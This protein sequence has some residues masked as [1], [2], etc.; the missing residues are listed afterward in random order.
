MFTGLIEE[1][2]EVQQMK[3]YGDGFALTV[4]APR[5]TGSLAVGDSVNIDGVCQTV[6]SIDGELFSVVTIEET[7]KKT[8]LGEKRPG[9]HVNLERAL[10]ADSRLGGHFVLGHADTTGTI[11]SIEKLTA[12]AV[13]T[14]GYP[15]EFGKY[16]IPVGSI[17]VDGISLTLAEVEARRFKVAIIPH[18]LQETVLPHKAAGAKVNLEFDVL[19]K[20]VARMFD[21]DKPDVMTEEWLKKHGF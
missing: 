7:L 10:R 2:G 13:Y 12:S 9:T 17:A 4:A 5:I 15:K 18:T 14:I 6:T 1:V 8:T 20:Y 19:G 21:K 11:E 16:L 3:P